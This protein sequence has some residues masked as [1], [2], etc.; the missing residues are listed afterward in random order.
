MI[1]LNLIVFAYLV[2]TT[3]G[4]WYLAHLV[5]E[6]PAEPINIIGA[7]TGASPIIGIGHN[8]KIG[9]GITVSMVDTK[10]NFIEKMFHNGTYEYLGKAMTPRVREEIIEIKGQTPHVEKII[11]VG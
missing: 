4:Q 10:D 5:N 6:D 8:N 9:W 7:T 11:E 1:I 2:Q 3:P